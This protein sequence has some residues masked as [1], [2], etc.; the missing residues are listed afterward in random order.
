MLFLP[1]SLRYVFCVLFVVC[2]PGTQAAPQESTILYTETFSAAS[3]AWEIRSDATALYLI[4][5]GEYLLHQIARS[6]A[7]ILC[8][9]T[10]SCDPFQLKTSL[11]VD[12]APGGARSAGLIF[13][14]QYDNSGGFLVEVNTKKQYRIR[15]VV[16]GSYRLLTGTIQNQGWLDGP[17]R[18]AGQ[19][20]M[21]RLAYADKGY[22]IYVNESLVRSYTEPSYKIGRFGF[23]VGPNTTAHIDYVT[24]QATG[25]CYGIPGANSHVSVPGDSLGKIRKLEAE[26]K[27]LKNEL[28]QLRDSLQLKQASE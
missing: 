16:K 14:M 21:I 23:V 6:E 10:H 8:S 19:F 11:K 3:G 18:P 27:R 4:Q 26:V 28:R 5:D 13:M 9:W 20:N 1:T 24:V 2:L 7:A 25:E 22:E 15:Q 17:V 12:A